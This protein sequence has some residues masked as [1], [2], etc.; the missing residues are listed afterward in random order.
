MTMYLT[1]SDGTEADCAPS[2]DIA[3]ADRDD[4]EVWSV[5]ENLGTADRDE[6]LRIVRSRGYTPVSVAG[7]WY[8]DDRDDSY[9]L[10]PAVEEPEGTT[11]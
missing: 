3:T 1:Y 2:Y 11:N 7:G 9:R 8:G 10:D 6:A 4:P 5:V